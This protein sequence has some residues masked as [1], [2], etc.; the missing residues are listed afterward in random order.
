MGAVSL[1]DKRL[2]I[3]G[4][5]RGLGHAFAEAAIDAADFITGQIVPVDGDFVFN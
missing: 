5:A 2:V 1:H 3:T 4:A